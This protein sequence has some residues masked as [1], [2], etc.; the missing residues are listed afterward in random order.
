MP[1]S[2]SRFFVNLSNLE[3]SET[4]LCQHGLGVH[5]MSIWYHRLLSIVCPF[6]TAKILGTFVPNALFHSLST[7]V[8]GTKVDEEWKSCQENAGG[9][10]FNLGGTCEAVSNGQTVDK[11]LW[12]QMDIR[13]TPN[14][15][16][17]KTVSDRWRSLGLTK[18][19]EAD[20]GTVFVGYV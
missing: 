5:R 12:Y 8:P 20:F 1:K 4:F 13:W 18:N 16:W 14:P 15:C 3:R 7:L 2:A 10:C 11:S 19:L 6:E 17:H 9:S